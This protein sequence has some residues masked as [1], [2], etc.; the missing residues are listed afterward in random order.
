VAIFTIQNE[1]RYESVRKLSEGGMGVIWEAEQHGVKGF[2]KRYP[3]ADELLYDLQHYIYHSGYGPTNETLGRFIR[4]LFGQ[5]VPTSG[6]RPA[7]GSTMVLEE[8]ASRLFSN[9]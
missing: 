8:C 9:H 5:N 3:T 4:Q 7:R 2:V 6:S 1:F